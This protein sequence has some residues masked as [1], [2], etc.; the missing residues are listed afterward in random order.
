[1][2]NFVFLI[3]LLTSSLFYSNLAKAQIKSDD[4]IPNLIKDVDNISIAGNSKLNNGTV[5]VEF[6]QKL[7]EDLNG[8]KYII[9][10]T[11]VGSWSGLYIEEINNNG[12]IVKSESG[13]LNANFFWLLSSTNTILD[14]K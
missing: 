5:F 7:S 1:M 10:L 14:K 2:K 6:P 12:F 3:I 4:A 8:Q 13:D 9:N 11:A